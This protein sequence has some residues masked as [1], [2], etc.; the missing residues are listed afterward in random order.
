MDKP[1]MKFDKQTYAEQMDDLMKKIEITPDYDLYVK[2]INISRV[3]G[4]LAKCNELR[5]RMTALYPL[6]E[7]ELTST[8]S[9]NDF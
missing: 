3:N 1:E 5:S 7:S 9:K 8:Y 2:A 4:D 6:E